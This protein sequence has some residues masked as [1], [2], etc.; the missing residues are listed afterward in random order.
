MSLIEQTRVN[1]RDYRAWTAILDRLN[2]LEGEARLI[3]KSLAYELGF[4]RKDP[5]DLKPGDL[6]RSHNGN[7]REVESKR[8]ACVDGQ[9]D[10]DDHPR[11]YTVTFT[12]GSN[13]FYETPSEH[14]PIPETQPVTVAVPEDDGLF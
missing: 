13:G 5:A 12:D 2:R 10:C 7:Y 1:D 8:Y 11:G 3:R 6:V 4:D 14:H 9:R